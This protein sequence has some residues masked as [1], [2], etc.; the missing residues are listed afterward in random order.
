MQSQN[1]GI[2]DKIL[3]SQSQTRN[4][5]FT[6]IELLVVIAILAILIAI[7]IPVA[8]RALEGANRTKCSN[9]L[10]NIA[11]AMHLYLAD[12]KAI[13]PDFVWNEQYRQCEILHD[14]LADPQ[15]YICPS[16][17]RDGSSGKNWPEYYSTTIEGQEFTT[18]YKI[19]DAQRLDGGTLSFALADT[20]RFIIACDID[21][22][23]PLR[24]SGRGNFVFFDGHVETMTKEESDQADA[25]GN[26]PWY[27]WGTQ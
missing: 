26:V 6:L 21:W 17:Q 18:D 16:A 13:F 2:A 10:G 25:R 15:V 11:K 8:L 22:V 3:P 14:Y 19:N 9:N 4:P 1:N 23:L 7:L 12:N 5:G 20:S 27:N 24:H